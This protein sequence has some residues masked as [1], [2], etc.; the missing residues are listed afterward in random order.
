MFQSGIEYWLTLKGTI[1]EP[2]KPT[3]APSTP[4]YTPPVVPS[5][6]AP[7]YPSSN[8]T[9]PAPPAATGTQPAPPAG[10]T[11]APPAFTGAA[12]K[13]GVSLLGVAG[14]LAAFL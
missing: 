8:G 5:A 12:S 3:Y 1:S 14:V 13:M 9:V 6:P 10:T 7:V 11:A 2:V 4:V